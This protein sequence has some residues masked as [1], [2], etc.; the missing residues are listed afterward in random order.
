MSTHKAPP[1]IAAA[2]AVVLSAPG[3]AAA[4]S[5][6]GSKDTRH[7]ISIGDSLAA[8]YQPDIDKD[9]HVAYIAVEGADGAGSGGRGHRGDASGGGGRARGGVEDGAEGG[10]RAGRCECDGADL[11]VAGAV[12]H[13]Q[14][15]LRRRTGGE[16]SLAHPLRGARRDGEGRG[17]GEAA[18]CDRAPA[19]AFGSTG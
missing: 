8:G 4:D 11:E 5:P 1:L 14:C 17:G 9:T 13:G 7:Y 12:V 6:S 3:V 15:Q 2:L 16:G 10:G 19:A 18:A